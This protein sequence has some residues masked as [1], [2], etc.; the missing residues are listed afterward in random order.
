VAGR[1]C[2]VPGL[3]IKASRYRLNV[4]NGDVTLTGALPAGGPAALPAGGPA[5]LLAGG[6]A[7][8]NLASTV[9]SAF[10]VTVHGLVAPHP[11]PVKVVNP[12]PESGVAVSVTWVPSATVVE[13]RLFARAPPVQSIPG[14]VTVPDPLPDTVTVNVRCGGAAANLWIRTL[15]VSATYTFPVASLD[16]RVGA[17]SSP[18]SPPWAPAWQLAATV[19]IPMPAPP[20]SLPQA[21]RKLPDESNLSIRWLLKSA[22]YTLPPSVATPRGVWNSPPSPPNAPP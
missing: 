16:T 6:A 22:T 14:P 15:P 21:R 8:S 18:P 11:P 13:H 2:Q 1:F 17:L 4:T 20:T 7:A 19:Q 10:M 5:G 9:W 12:E 3:Q